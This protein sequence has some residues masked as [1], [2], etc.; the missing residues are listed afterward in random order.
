M[1]F[2]TLFMAVA[3]A[4]V[5]ANATV[6]ISINAR[7]KGIPSVDIEA[8]TNPVV[9]ASFEDVLVTGLISPD[10]TIGPIDV[11]SHSVILDESNGGAPVPIDF[12]TLT[13]GDITT[14]CPPGTLF[15]VCQPISLQFEAEGAPTFQADLAALPAGTPRL[16]I[17]TGPFQDLTTLLGSNSYIVVVLVASPVTTPEP[18][19][20]ALVGLVFLFVWWKTTRSSS[21]NRH[22]VSVRW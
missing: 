16:P 5:P 19:S 10:N 7:E 3:I 18:A 11:A 13:G 15:G 9:N 22:K 14:T 8:L 17:I 12:V 1:R 20:L 2:A 6:T 21:Y 4:S